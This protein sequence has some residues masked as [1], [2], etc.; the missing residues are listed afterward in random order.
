[1]RIALSKTQVER[2]VAE[3]EELDG[4]YTID[5]YDEPKPFAL[6]FEVVETG[7]YVTAALDLLYDEELEGYYL[8]EAIEPDLTES[9]VRAWLGAD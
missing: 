4:E 3:A 2:M 5:L 7:I 1:M 9:R 6:E 8:G